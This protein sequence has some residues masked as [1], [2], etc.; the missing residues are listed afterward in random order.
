[1]KVGE[2]TEQ[3][4]QPGYSRGPR[5]PIPARKRALDLVLIFVSAVL[6]I[7][8]AAAITVFIKLVSRGP[9]LFRQERIGHQ[10]RP[11]MCLKFR[12]MKVGSETATHRHHLQ[13]LIQSQTPMTKL[14]VKGD[15]RLIPFGAMLRATGLDEL[16]QLI[17]VLR[18]EMSLVGPRPA[19]PYE[20]EK[21][22]EWHWRRFDAQPGLTGWWQVGGKN[23]TTF[24]EMIQMDI[25]YAEHQSLWLDLKII[26]FTIPALIAQVLE[27]RQAS[28][29]VG[30]QP[31]VKTL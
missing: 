25:W 23:R 4:R 14:D 12:T 8:L 22:A 7:P 27:V 15:A 5:I 24:D 13:Q 31:V 16:P 30:A 9:A 6:T 26:L 11:F 1:M 19:V 28:R 3:R 29:S 2:R 20:C 18:G 17:N 21:Y 10:G